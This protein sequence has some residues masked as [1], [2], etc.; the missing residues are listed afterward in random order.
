MDV[1][2]KGLVVPTAQR[3]RLLAAAARLT[4]LVP[5]Q[6]SEPALSEAQGGDPQPYFRLTPRGAGLGVVLVVRPLGERGPA[7]LPGSGSPLILAHLEGAIAQARRDLTL[8]V[9]QAAA[10]ITACP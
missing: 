5:L 6:S 7:C 4:H 10:A 8:E 3:E 1:V 2:G 9:R